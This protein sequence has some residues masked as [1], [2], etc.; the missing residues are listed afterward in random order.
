MRQLFRQLKAAFT[1]APVIAHFGPAK[2][3]Q[4]ETDVSG[5][6]IAGIFSEQEREVG[7]ATEC[8]S[9]CSERAMEHAAERAAEHAAKGHWNLVA[10]W[11]RSMLPAE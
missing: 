11:S 3:I 7:E 10:N 6:E 1:S 9:H 2:L 8:L 4:L 5:Y